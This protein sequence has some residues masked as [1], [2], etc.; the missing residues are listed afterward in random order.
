MFQV[1][2]WFFKN[3]LFLTWNYDVGSYYGLTWGFEFLNTIHSFPAW[4]QL[5]RAIIYPSS[6][7]T[8]VACVSYYCYHHRCNNIL[9]LANKKKTQAIEMPLL[10]KMPHVKLN[11]SR[12]RWI[13]CLPPVLLLILHSF[14]SHCLVILSY[15]SSIFFKK[16]FGLSIKFETYLLPGNFTLPVF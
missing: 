1:Q 12:K 3:N 9:A 11:S 2:Y 5:I 8:P 16:E 13:H 4:V 10:C 6:W 15:S 7:R 14:F